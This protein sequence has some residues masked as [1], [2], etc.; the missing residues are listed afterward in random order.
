M[1]SIGL[2]VNSRGVV[3]A[4]LDAEGTYFVEIKAGE[5]KS[6]RFSI[7]VKASEFASFNNFAIADFGAPI[8]WEDDLVQSIKKVETGKSLYASYLDQY[9]DVEQT[10]LLNH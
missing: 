7:T 1:S 5:V 10:L 4:G 3:S 9:G 8:D 2:T 6:E